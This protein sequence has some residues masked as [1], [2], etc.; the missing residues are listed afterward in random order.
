MLVLLRSG[1]PTSQ[2]GSTDYSFDGI[3]SGNLT[4]R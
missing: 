1:P 3:D 4:L 2:L